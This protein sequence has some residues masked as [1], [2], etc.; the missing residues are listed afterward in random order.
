[1]SRLWFVS[2]IVL[3]LACGSGA[4][5]EPTAT[6][7]QSSATTGT[8]I[9]ELRT[10]A[11]EPSEGGE[12]VSWQALELGEGDELSVETTDNQEVFLYVESGGLDR[13][14]E[15][16]V[17]HLRGSH[18][19]A[20]RDRTRV[21]GARAEAPDAAGQAATI[22]S[23]SL[24]ESPVLPNAGGKLRVQIFFDATGGSRF[25]AFS[26]LDGDADLGVPE[27]VHATSV[28]S[29]YVLSGDGEMIL[30]DERE[31]LEPG[32]VVYVPANTNHGY[33]HGTEPLRALQVYAPPGPEQRFRPE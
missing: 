1:M 3:G 29:L 21:I 12:L 10:V 33:E 28:E 24:D 11:F 2:L 14:G 23:S 13:Y 19:L 27:H 15:G 4:E 32:S 20:A 8:E 30:R 26:L 5:S 25:G 22:Q 6:T 18:S 9:P 16:S 7:D 31:A 17:L